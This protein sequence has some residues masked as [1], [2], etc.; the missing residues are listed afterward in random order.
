MMH[1][2]FY[3]GKEA[4]LLFDGWKTTTWLGYG[5]SLVA[6]FLLSTFYQ[7]IES[8]RISLQTASAVNTLDSGIQT[9]L[10]SNSGFAKSRCRRLAVAAFFGVS[11]AIGYLLMLSVMSF[12][13]GVFIAVVLGLT[14]GYLAFRDVDGVIVAAVASGSTCACA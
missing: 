1:M 13:A 5:L 3:W 11:S 8:F 6:L 9:P 12:N 4:T 10:L 14:V 2:T 7:Y